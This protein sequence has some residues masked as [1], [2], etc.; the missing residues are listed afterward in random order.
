MHL[1]A[2]DL[3]G[4]APE[5]VADRCW[6]AGAAGLWE[7]DDRTLRV[8]V[9][10][11]DLRRFLDALDDL[12]PV[13]VTDTEAVELA[14]RIGTIA[15]AGQ[16]LELWTPATVF[17]TGDHPTTASCLDALSTVVHTGDRVLDVGCGSGALTVA[18][19]LLGA[20]VTAIDIDPEAV[21]ATR[22]NAARNGVAVAAST[23]P[24]DRVE[25]VFDVV[26]ANLTAGALQPL[27][28]RLLARAR[29]GATLVLSGMLEEQWPDVRAAAGGT[30]HGIHVV[31]G[32]VTATVIIS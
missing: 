5:L 4:R 6:Q 25:G 7:V 27:V 32:W 30:V 10:A 28:P 11:G 2:I 29:A 13:D 18:A 3:S 1:V 17:G 24:I 19:G 12:E 22:A 15:F 26:L 23:T 9:G 16:D 31:D 21:D 8:G 14:G 20:K